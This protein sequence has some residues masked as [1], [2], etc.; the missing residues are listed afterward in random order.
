MKVGAWG[1]GWNTASTGGRSPQINHAQ[2]LKFLAT[3]IKLRLV[4]VNG[5]GHNDSGDYVIFTE[6]LTNKAGTVVKGYDSVRCTFNSTG[7]QQQI[8]CATASSCSTDR[9]EI[10]VYGRLRRWSR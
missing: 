1:R 6:R 8:R 4:D 7:H 5:N 2:K 10:T 9:G 3:T